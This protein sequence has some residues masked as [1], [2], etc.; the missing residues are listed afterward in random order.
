MFTWLLIL[1]SVSILSLVIRFEMQK[2]KNSITFSGILYALCSILVEKDT[3]IFGLTFV[4]HKKIPHCI[5]LAI[6]F[7][8][9]VLCNE[10]RG[11]NITKLTVQPDLYPFDRFD[12]LV[13]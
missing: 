11:D 8:S 10:H 13:K 6:P 4:K 2:A 5:T 7:I 1:A 3:K 9:L 12:D